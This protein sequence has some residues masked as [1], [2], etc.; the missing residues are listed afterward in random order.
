MKVEDA[1]RISDESQNDS[2]TDSLPPFLKPKLG[3]LQSFRR[4]LITGTLIIGPIALTIYLLF[5]LFIFLD[6]ILSRTIDYLLRHGFGLTFLGSEPI[7]G[8]GLITLVIL[9]VFVGWGTRN[10]IGRWV[11]KRSQEI[12]DRIPLVNG[13][14]K[15]FDQISQAIF[16]GRKDMFKRAVL[17]EYPSKGIY[18]IGVITADK[19]GIMQKYLPD[20]AV[21]V[22]ITTTPN[23]TTGFQIFVARK[24]IIELDMPIEDAMKIVISG[25]IVIPPEKKTEIG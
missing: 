14:Y 6:G 10:F 22:F 13:V 24:D 23:P 18:S 3:L 11:I 16:S 25:G 7:P 21:S 1:I 2:T 17:I 19:L 12:L 9:V 4:N 5:Y 15:T 20:Q 8:L